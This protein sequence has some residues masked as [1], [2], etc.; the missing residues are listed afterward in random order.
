MVRSPWLWL[1]VG[2]LPGLIA[3]GLLFGATGPA[4]RAL[5]TAAG[6]LAGTLVLATAAGYAA[7]QVTP[8]SPGEMS[9]LPGA[10][11]LAGAAGGI[12]L[13]TIAGLRAWRRARREPLA[14]TAPPQQQEP[15]EDA[16]AST[17]PQQDQEHGQAATRPPRVVVVGC[18]PQEANNLEQA[19]Q[20][21]ADTLGRSLLVF[22]HPRGQVAA[23]PCG[24][25]IAVRVR[26]AELHPVT[27]AIFASLGNGATQAQRPLERQRL[28]S[29]SPTSPRRL[30]HDDL[31]AAVGE[32]KASKGEG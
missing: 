29:A 22:V 21:V 4:R 2:G 13:A 28:P 16:S 3:W 20:A 14:P 11:F 27:Q 5:L 19:L 32:A 1:L 24:E 6:I 10:V 17:S 31:V 12:A 18:S 9:I 15:G 23:V 30:R 7:A 8:A 25:V 26:Q